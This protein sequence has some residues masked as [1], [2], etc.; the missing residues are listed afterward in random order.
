MSD[1]VDYLF[2]CGWVDTG[3]L[4]CRAALRALIAD[5]QI[6]KPTG[7]FDQVVVADQAGICD[8]STFCFRPTLISHALRLTLRSDAGG[9]VELRVTTCGGVNI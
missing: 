6:D 4:P 5:R 9:A 2:R 1:T 3:N 7:S 8:F